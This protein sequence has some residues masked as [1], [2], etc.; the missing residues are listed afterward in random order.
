MAFFSKGKFNNGDEKERAG[1]RKVKYGDMTDAQKSAYVKYLVGN[2][3][4]FSILLILIIGIPLYLYFFQ[5][6]FFH[7]LRSMKD[8]KE[9][10]LAQG[11]SA[12]IAYLA[13]Q[14]LQVIISI[15]PG[16][17]LQMAAGYIFGFRIGF[18]TSVIGVT[19]GSMITFYLG[20]F[21]GQDAMKMM[22]GELRF[23]KFMEK[24]NSKRGFI[25][26]FILNLIPGGPK[27]LL[28]YVAGVSNMRFGVFVTVVMSAR[29]PA[30]CASILFG[31]FVDGKNYIAVTVIVVAVTISMLLIYFKRAELDRRLNYL[32]EKYVLKGRQ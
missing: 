28:C 8:A 18:L 4:K 2:V 29:I 1:E 11:N 5:R 13:I 27:D 12:I 15:I 25:V 16:N 9:F 22:F 31:K 17:I 30:L 3:L 19:L 6:D 7:S 10:L 32:Y 26:L 23:A 20:R 24:C 21:L 14:I